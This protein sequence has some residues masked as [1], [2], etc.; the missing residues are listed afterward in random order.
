MK[1]LINLYKKES[2]AVFE[3]L[4]NEQLVKFTELILQAYENE[5][6]IFACGNGGNIAYVGN[7]VVDLNMHPFVSE[8]KETRS[9]E[10]NKFHCVNLCDCS[11][12]ITGI[13]NDL[14]YE[15]IFSEQLLYQAKKD[16]VFFGITGSGNSKNVLKALKYAHKSQMK[17][18]VITRNEDCRA[19]ELADLL[20]VVRGNSTFPGQ[21]GKNNNNFHFEDC[22]SKITHIAVG[23]LKKK[24]YDENRTK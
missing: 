7:F 14:G 8:D 10:R 17:S 6:T 15:N 18:V 2:S 3:N 1:K 11:A 22:I 9:F 5:S 13:S 21:T 24:V 12:T 4:D 23:I 20:I 16:D 19:R